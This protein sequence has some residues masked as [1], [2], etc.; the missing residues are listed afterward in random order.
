MR[1]IASRTGCTLWIGLA[2]TALGCGPQLIYHDVD[3]STVRRDGYANCLPAL[4]P[5]FQS[6]ACP[7]W[8]LPQPAGVD[9]CAA[10]RC[11]VQC[12]GNNECLPPHG[13]T[14]SGLCEQG[15]CVLYCDGDG[16][17]ANGMACL[18]DPADQSARICAWQTDDAFYCDAVHG[19]DPCAQ[20]QNELS[21]VGGGSPLLLDYACQ[22]V[23]EYDY[24]LPSGNC[25]PP[26]S[27]SSCIAVLQTPPSACEAAHTCG[28]NQQSVYWRESGP[29]MA[30]LLVL[31]GCEQP[32]D[33]QYLPCDFE[34]TLALPIVCGC[35]C[36][37]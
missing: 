27:R 3:E 2:L 18:A 32:F 37:E 33:P 1:H 19:Q 10:C 7:Q 8:G 17:C 22:W 29:S 9:A 4:G 35:Q 31:D 34:S 23:R 15:S 25:E 20:F 24:V 13:V 36:P 21:C 14:G 28:T 30:K 16:D 26:R 12:T 11:Q 5:E 6:E